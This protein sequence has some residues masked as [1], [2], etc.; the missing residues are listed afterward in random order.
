[1]SC[2]KDAALH[3]GGRFVDGLVTTAG[4][5]TVGAIQGL[6]GSPANPYVFIPGTKVQVDIAVSSLL[7]LA[8]IAGF[9]GKYSGQFNNYAAGMIAAQVHLP[10]RDAIVRMRQR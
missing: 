4:G 3:V 10:V 5:A 9:F 2:G 7:E 1:M 8:A 6:F